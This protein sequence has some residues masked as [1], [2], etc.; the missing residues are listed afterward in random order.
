MNEVQQSASFHHTHTHTHTH[1]HNFITCQE[2]V[3]KQDF[4]GLLYSTYTLY[5]KLFLLQLSL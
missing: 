4:W 5:T 2:K 1:T 3:T